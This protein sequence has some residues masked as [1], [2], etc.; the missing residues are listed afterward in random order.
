[1]SGLQKAVALAGQLD[2]W[3]RDSYCQLRELLTLS[4]TVRPRGPGVAPTAEGRAG[5]SCTAKEWSS[6]RK[7]CY[8]AGCRSVGCRFDGTPNSWAVGIFAAGS[9]TA[10]SSA[11]AVGG[12]AVAAGNWV[13]EGFAAA[14]KSPA[15]DFARGWT[16]EQLVP[17]F[18]VSSCRD[19]T[20]VVV[21]LDVESVAELV[22]GQ[23]GSSL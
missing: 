17:V 3:R 14:G 21:G 10:R 1:M 8:S 20:L 22:V 9:Q 5:G 11:A 23:M 12:F 13:V 4:L 2:R 18:A 15:A 7:D 19:S 16:L 6:Y